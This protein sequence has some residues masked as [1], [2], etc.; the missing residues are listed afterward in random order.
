MS[1]KVIQPGP[2]TTVQDLGRLGFQK[3]GVSVSG[4]CDTFALRV[5]NLLVGNPENEAALE[6]TLYGTTL[7]FNENHLI[8]ICGGD[9]Q[10]EINGTRAGLWRPIFVKKGA[11]LHIPPSYSGARLYLAVSGGID[12][13]SILGSKSTYLRA[14]FGGFQGRPLKKDDI[15]PIGPPPLNS[16]SI[17]DLLKK[18]HKKRSF[19]QT[20]W[21]VSQNLLP[22][23]QTTPII[24]V[25]PSHE[26]DLFRAPSINAFYSSHY[27]VTPQSDRMGY[28][29][30]GEKLELMTVQKRLSEPL[31]AGTVQVPPNGQPIL[32]L[33]DRQSIG[34]YPSIGHVATV[35]LPLVAQ[36]KPG[37]H[38][39]FVKTTLEDAQ[40]AFIKREKSIQ[41]LKRQIHERFQ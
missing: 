25:I 19:F 11:V 29:L 36:T 21:S 28:R 8:S 37:D 22:N 18:A 38:L 7:D 23:Y 34:G 5:S 14:G 9:F 32:L 15:L 16:E 24:R 31:T 41:I 10:P 35:D 3:I 13:P 1:I 17:I 30:K 2:L 4:A 39:N 40:E 26:T 27:E 6:M 20:S 33:A 12:V